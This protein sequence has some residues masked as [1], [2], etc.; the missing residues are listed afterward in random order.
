MVYQVNRNPMAKR[1]ADMLDIG[2]RVE[3]IGIR[4]PEDRFEVASIADQGKID[5]LVQMI[6]DAPFDSTY[7]MNP[8]VKLVMLSIYL[9]DGTRVGGFFW[10]DSGILSPPNLQ[11]PLEFSA[12]IGQAIAAER[13][14]P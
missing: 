13:E 1:G 5:E 3:R 2:G 11:L 4:L 14:T 7:L 10:L 9:L 6:L 8:G 12:A